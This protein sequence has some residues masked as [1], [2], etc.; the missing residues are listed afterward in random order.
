ML[1]KYG[2][3]VAIPLI[4]GAVVVMIAGWF[5]PNLVFRGVVMVAGGLLLAFT[6]NFFRD[7]DRQTPEVEGGIIAPA[8]GKI[9][10]IKEV[11][12]PDR[13]ESHAGQYLYV[14]AGCAREQDPRFWKSR[15]FSLY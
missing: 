11:D 9:V 5:I 4:I 8:D 10:L 15:V 14:A 7:P 2:T 12:E 6:L 3:D 13:G 1:T